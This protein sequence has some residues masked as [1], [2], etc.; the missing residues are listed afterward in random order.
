MN[1]AAIDRNNASII[2]NANDISMI[3]LS[4]ATY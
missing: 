4:I 3:P 1:T 2:N